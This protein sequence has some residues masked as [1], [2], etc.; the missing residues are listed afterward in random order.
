MEILQNN[1]NNYSV[2][3]IENGSNYVNVNN[4]S[5]VEFARAYVASY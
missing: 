3:K 2:I 1:D 4:Y 5:I